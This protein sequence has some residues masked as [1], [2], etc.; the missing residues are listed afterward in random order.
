VPAGGI[1]VE[2]TSFKR[3]IENMDDQGHVCKTTIYT[4]NWL[5]LQGADT[6]G[7]RRLVNARD[8]YS[9]KWVYRRVYC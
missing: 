5:K 1:N 9:Q 4:F 2:T 7:R 3:G 6:A 8:F